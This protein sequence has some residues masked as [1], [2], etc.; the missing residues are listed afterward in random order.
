MDEVHRDDSGETLLEIVIS[1]LMIGL[2]VSA[3]VTAIGAGATLTI[4]HRQLTTADVALKGAAESVKAAGFATGRTSTQAEADY[5]SALPAP[6]NGF[7]ADVEQVSCV[8]SRTAATYAAFA[9]VACT[10]VATEQL[11]LVRVRVTS[12]DT[13]EVTTLM[14]RKS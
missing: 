7:T 9:A 1:I 8:P 12:A 11:H 10:G 3:L 13:N 5:Q 4:G 2:A 6:P 14:K